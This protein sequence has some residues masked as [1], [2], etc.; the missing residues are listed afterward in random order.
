MTA[1]RTNKLPYNKKLGYGVGALSYGIP[2]QLIS[3]FFLFYATEILQIS[4]TLAGTIISIS[5]IW[6]AISDPVM[7]YVSDH[8][9]RNILFGRRL[10]YVLIGAIGI[11]VTNF[12][13]WNI[14]ASMPNIQKAV[15]LGV[16]LLLVKTFST[17]LTTPYLALGAELS[18]DYIE[19]TSVQSFRTAFFFLGFLFPTVIGMGLYFRP[20]PDFANGQM[21]PSAY[22]SL[23]LTASL[24]VL[25]CAA[26]CIVLTYK[27]DDTHIPNPVKKKKVSFANMFRETAD[28]LKCN[29]FRNVSLS[30]LFINMAMGVVGAVGMHVFTF[31]FG[32]TSSQIAIVFSSLFVMALVGQ[33]VWVAVVK[34]YEKRDVLIACLYANIGIAFLFLLSVLFCEWISAHYLAMLPLSMLIGISMGGS[35]ALPY[36]MISDTIDKN[37]YNSG[38]RKEGVFYGCATFMYKVS[39]ALS[40]LFV[41]TLIDI[42]GFDSDLLQAHRVYVKLGMI[43][44][45]GFLVCFTLAL[46]F[47]KKYTLDR[48]LVEKYQ[49]KLPSDD[50]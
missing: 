6:D 27:K 9:N 48:Q 11:A 20:T 1:R 33:P 47:A 16:L 24:I 25:V 39:Q 35:V 41:G 44:P 5:I 31:T 8:T 45:I 43:L 22:S 23:G 29:D 10:F 3:G 46:I 49:Q 2:F 36:A 4:G 21:N 42:I 18:S 34:K 14:D 30:L 50:H 15:S 19:R 37:A 7:G 17:V 26:I 13:L 38:V 32:F 28:A 40:V 12:F